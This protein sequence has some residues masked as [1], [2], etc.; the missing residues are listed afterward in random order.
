MN[1]VESTA[2]SS[3]ADHL[4]TSQYRYED[5]AELCRLGCKAINLEK[6]DSARRYFELAAQM[7]AA[8]AAVSLELMYNQG[9]ISATPSA[10]YYQQ[11]KQD[12]S[13]TAVFERRHVAL[14]QRPQIKVSYY[15]N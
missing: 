15:L 4:V 9:Y 13:Q 6:F 12:L 10:R 2:P 14:K 3:V 5:A 1:T 11:Q 7:G 8:E